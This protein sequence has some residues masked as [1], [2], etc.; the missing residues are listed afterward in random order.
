MNTTTN[1][2]GRWEMRNGKTQRLKPA[3]GR[4]EFHRV[5]VGE[6]SFTRQGKHHELVLRLISD[7][8]TLPKGQAIA[9]PKASLKTKFENLRSAIKNATRKEKMQIR[10]GS[11]AE[12]FYI[13]KI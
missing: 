3:E 6:I 13:W 10:T 4:P 1:P 12:H 8:E 5:P 9:V 7:L 11:D 2:V